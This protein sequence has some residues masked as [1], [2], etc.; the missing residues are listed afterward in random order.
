MAKFQVRYKYGTAPTDAA[1]DAIIVE[2]R[3][4]PFTT[5]ANFVDFYS[6]SDLAAYGGT[7]LPS[8]RIAHRSL[9]E[10]MDLLASFVVLEEYE[11]DPENPE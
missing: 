7:F 3:C 9:E 6:D 11:D 4:L 2:P 5:E 10:I 8:G 1:D